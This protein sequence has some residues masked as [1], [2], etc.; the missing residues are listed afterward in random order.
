[1]SLI[2]PSRNA[3]SYLFKNMET[4]EY[5]FNGEKV[6]V[7][8]WVWGVVY[9][10]G[11]ELHQFGADGVYHQIGE[12]KQEEITMFTMYKFDDLSKRIDMPICE[13]MKII[14]KHRNIRPH[15]DNVFKRVCLFGYKKDGKY[16][17]NFILPDDRIIISPVDN[18]DLSLFNV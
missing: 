3:R 14:H 12:I 18:I 2:T 16:S 9:K 15:Y 1:M 11:S 10:D 4:K 13:G 6:K 8:R 5:T 7:E 17:F